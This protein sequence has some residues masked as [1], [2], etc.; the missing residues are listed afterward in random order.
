MILSLADS[1]PDMVMLL[2]SLAQT[3]PEIGELIEAEIVT[4]LRAEPPDNGSDTE[5]LAHYLTVATLALVRRLA[6]GALPLDGIDQYLTY[7]MRACD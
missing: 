4:E 5:L 6:S 3:Q 7:L 2:T 1:D